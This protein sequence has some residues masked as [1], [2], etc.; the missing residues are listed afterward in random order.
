LFNA[1]FFR[2]PY[3]VYDKLRANSPVQRLDGAMGNLPTWLITGYAEARA[4]LTDPRISKDTRRFQHIFDQ[5]GNKRNINPAVSATMLATD[6][7]DHTRLRKLVA[8]AFTTDTV[9]I[10]RPRIQQITDDLLDAIIPAGHADLIQTFAAPL[11]VTVISELLGVP[12][13]DRTNL[14]WWSNDNFAA[15][16]P[17]VRDH[18]SHAITDYMADLITVKRAQP[19]DDLLSALIAA[20]DDTDR[21]SE[22]ELVSLAVLL[23]IAGHETT[24]SLIGNAVLAL[25]LNPEQHTALLADPRLL[26]AAIDEFLRHAPPVATATIRFTTQPITIGQVTIPADQVILVSLGAANH[27]PA[28]FFDPARLDVTRDSAGH[29]AFGHGIHFCIGARLARTETGIALS[30]L[31]ARLPGLQLAA[32]PEN[33]QWRHS[34]IMRG[35]ES[36]PVRW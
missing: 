35:L 9:N 5:A 34:R 13:S 30:S 23:L 12:E 28:R 20:R 7:P 17:A 27:D 6:P 16:D 31:L 25:L 24:T 22:H 26:P 21:L 15:G 1:D 19:G 18:A 4:A 29:L 33:L 8:K 10:L 36:L 32:D 2:D 14:R 3:P 11:P